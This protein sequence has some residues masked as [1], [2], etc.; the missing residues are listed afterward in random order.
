MQIAKGQALLRPH[1]GQQHHCA[2]ACCRIVGISGQWLLSSVAAGVKR[3]AFNPPLE[4]DGFEFD[5]CLAEACFRL[6]LFSV[7][8]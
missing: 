4:Q 7:P 1:S 6:I 5:S 8:M 2:L 3:L